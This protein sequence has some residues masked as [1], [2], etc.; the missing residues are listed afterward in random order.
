MFPVSFVS[1][2]KEIIIFRYSDVHIEFQSAYFDTSYDFMLVTL[3]SY[4]FFGIRKLHRFPC[5]W[6]ANSMI[7]LDTLRIDPPYDRVICFATSGG[8]AG[9][10]TVIKVV[11]E[12]RK[13]LTH[14]H[15]PT[16][17]FYSLLPRLAHSKLMI[18]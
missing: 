17:Y 13:L 18:S 1:H 10:E 16:F 15:Q 6:Q 5:R 3:P 9:M 11:S 2:L 8:D 7:V 4:I 14:S 12:N